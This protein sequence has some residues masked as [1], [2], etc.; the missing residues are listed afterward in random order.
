MNARNAAYD[1]LLKLEKEKQYS[2]IAVNH[3]ILRYDFDKLERAFYTQ[4]VYGVIEKRITLDYLVTQYTEKSPKRLDLSVLILLRLSLYQIFFL[5]SVPESAAVSEGVKL[6]ARY[7]S[8]AKGYINAILR[9]ACREAPIYPEEPHFP[10]SYVLSVRYSV[11]EEIVKLLLEQY[12]ESCEG[13][14]NAYNSIPTITLQVN[15]AFGTAER[16]IEAYQLDAQTVPPLPFAVKFRSSVSVSD[17][18]FL[19]NGEAFVQDTASQFTSLILDPQP[20]DHIIDVCACPGGKTFSCANLMRSRAMNTDFSGRIISC[21]LHESKLSL[22]QSGAK[23]LSFDFIETVCHDATQTVDKWID[24]ADRIICDAPCSGLGVINK[25][26]EIRYKDISEIRSIPEIQYQ[27]LE[28]SSQYLKHGGTLLYSTCTL[29]R[30]ENEDIV[31]RFLKNHP[32]FSYEDFA[33]ESSIFSYCSQKGCLTL[34]PNE[35][36]DGFFI[37]KL[38]RT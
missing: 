23:R 1:T 17:M 12:A 35:W 28:T 21:D 19:Q 8:R 32:E 4:L 5:D 3:A 37:A 29:N 24:S 18:P 33:I 6:A 20:N 2:N 10:K 9:K 16:F 11:S 7:A 27:I 26:P 15:S 34:L 31:E 22:V 14:L 25:K 13:I 38:K 36:H 30:R